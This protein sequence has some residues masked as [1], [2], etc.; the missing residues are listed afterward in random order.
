VTWPPIPPLYNSTAASL[1][2]GEPGFFA[3]LPSA[4][5]RTRITSGASGK[6]GA[7]AQISHW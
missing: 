1:A 3:S 2:E 4:S 6:R 7:Q 5:R